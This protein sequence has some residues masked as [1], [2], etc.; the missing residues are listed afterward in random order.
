MSLAT[1]CAGVVFLLLPAE[2]AYDLPQVPAPWSCLYNVAD[3]LNLRYNL[4]PSLHVAL[5]LICVDAYSRRAAVVGRI[6][7]W[8]WGFAIALA[9]LL[10]HQHHVLDV[11]TGVLL[12]MVVS[13]RVH[14]GHG[15]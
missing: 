2:L 10:T 8:A 11:A 5:S 7:L 6:F 12:A 15:K 1:L 3:V 9:T 14:L 4:V 13:R